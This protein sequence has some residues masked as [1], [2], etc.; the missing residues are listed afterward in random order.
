MHNHSVFQYCMLLVAKSD[1]HYYAILILGVT[2]DV[3][4]AVD[5]SS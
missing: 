1:V 3:Q 4:L 5:N 2:P